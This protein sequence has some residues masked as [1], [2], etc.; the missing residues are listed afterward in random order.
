MHRGCMDSWY[1]A[2]GYSLLRCS[3]SASGAACTRACVT[4]VCILHTG[5]PLPRASPRAPASTHVPKPCMQPD[6]PSRMQLPN[7]GVGPI[8]HV[9]ALTV[10]ELLGCTGPVVLPQCAVD[11]IHAHGLQ[12]LVPRRA[13][14]VRIAFRDG[15]L[16]KERCDADAL[17]QLHRTTPISSSIGLRAARE[18]GN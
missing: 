10:H 4:W 7:V 15:V 6:S 3:A 14:A 2:T 12:H 11:S 5:Y 16:V 8:R 13:P 17:V 9:G 18:P 1:G